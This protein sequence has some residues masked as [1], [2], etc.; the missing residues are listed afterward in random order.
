MLVFIHGGAFQS[1]SNSTDRLGP[2]YLLTEDIV[3]VIPN[4]RLGVLGFL[5]LDDPSLEVPGNAGLKD[6]NLALQWVHRNIAKFNGDTKNITLSGHSTGAI[7]THHHILSS[8][9]RDLFH[10]AI[11][12]SCSVLYLWNMQDFSLQT[13]CDVL[14]IKIENERKVLQTLR[15]LPVEVLFEAQE[16]YVGVSFL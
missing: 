12:Q 13:F 5:I 7:S 4:Y 10:K 3:L 15:S 11:V 16:K 9:S 8:S 1:G 6:Q 2:E 14:N